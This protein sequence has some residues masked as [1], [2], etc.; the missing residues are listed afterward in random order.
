MSA[1]QP[2]EFS[3]I[4]TRISNYQRF[5]AHNMVQTFS[6]GTLN[7]I[8][9]LLLLLMRVLYRRQNN[10]GGGRCRNRESGGGKMRGGLNLKIHNRRLARQKRVK[11]ALESET[12]HV[13]K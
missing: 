7:E 4:S 12:E 9:L 8:M 13:R 3:L 10:S 11:C 5:S 1:R 2:V 6:V